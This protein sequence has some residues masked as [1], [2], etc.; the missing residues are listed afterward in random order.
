MTGSHQMKLIL[1]LLIIASALGGCARESETDC[2][3][4]LCGHAW[5]V[6]LDSAVARGESRVQMQPND[7]DALLALADAYIEKARFIINQTNTR[8]DFWLSS[9]L[10]KIDHL[11]NE[12]VS[13]CDKVLQ[14]K[15]D[16]ARA[17]QLKGNSFRLKMGLSRWGNEGLLNAYAGSVSNLEKA[18]SLAPD[19]SKIW[20]D[21]GRAYG[22]YWPG[23]RKA[24]QAYE[25]AAAL[26]PN[27]LK[28][29]ASLQRYRGWGGDTSRAIIPKI[30]THD[31]EVLRILANAGRG[32]DLDG[33]LE[34]TRLVPIPV[35]APFVLGILRLV[36]E[37][38]ETSARLYEKV[39]RSSHHYLTDHLM[40]ANG[41]LYQHTAK[42]S[43]ATKH[44]RVWAQ[45]NNGMTAAYYFGWGPG[46][47]IGIS[48][49]KAYPTSPWAWIYAGREAPP[50]KG[51]DEFKKAME[52]DSN[53]ALP[54]YLTAAACVEDEKWSDA[55][56][57]LRETKR[58]A[59]GDEFVALNSHILSALVSARIG[60]I[61][62][63][64]RESELALKMDSVYVAFAMSQGVYG[65]EEWSHPWFLLDKPIGRESL[66]M[67][68]DRK[69]ASLLN[70]WSG[71][72][73]YRR[74]IF[75]WEQRNISFFQKAVELDPE[76]VE[77]YIAI[78]SMYSAFQLKDE[79]GLA[80]MQNALRRFPENA[81]L[82]RELGRLFLNN[83]Q[84][85]KAEQELGRAYQ[86]GDY[87]AKLTLDQLQ[88]WR[89]E[90]KK[91]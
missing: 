25:K 62:Q 15:Q 68:S 89:D 73:Y 16:V 64:L 53:L 30:I 12:A 90:Q 91:Q 82:H 52:L 81:R 46:L 40:L 50:G 21:L 65:R 87:E 70:L 27:N 57:W 56:R 72:S 85:E 78:A 79:H 11:I 34:E 84:T 76:N 20:Y 54:Y 36:S 29:Y 45:A 69:L 1:Y 33:Y 88:E 55:E 77:G 43:E 47:T 66:R 7:A 23:W 9:S 37:D 44:F 19:S 35:K 24:R 14:Q 71:W 80:F 4:S 2:D 18:V 61:A 8:E 75:V 86:L 74:A 17:Y 6:E 10:K 22:E 38:Y 48:A 59:S 60:N 58:K 63:V 13:L 39:V 26:D 49:S 31:P 42:T 67:P 41:Y 32:F 3:K 5:A 51:I 28:A 83:N